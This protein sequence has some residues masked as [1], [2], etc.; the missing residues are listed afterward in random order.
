VRPLATRLAARDLRVLGAPATLLTFAVAAG[1]LAATTI[2]ST[3]AFL[4]DSSRVVHGGALSATV[5]GSVPL[6]D[7]GDLLPAAV[8]DASARKSGIAPVLRFAGTTPNGPVDVLGVDAGSLAALTPVDRALFDGRAIASQLRTPAA[9][10]ALPGDGTRTL[11][12]SLALKAGAA[13]ITELDPYGQPTGI[14]DPVAQGTVDVSAIAWLADPQGDLAPVATDS[15]PMG[16]DA[17]STPTVSAPVPPGGPWRLIA[18]DLLA[19]SD[20]DVAEASI[21][22]TGIR[23][24]STDVRMPSAAWRVATDAYDD[25]ALRT[26]S[27]T[28]AIGVSTAA[29]RSSTDVGVAVR[30]VPAGGGTVPVAISSSL[31]QAQALHVGSV[32]AVDS[33]WAGLRGRVAAIVP[34]VPGTDGGPAVLADLAT[35][36]RGML[37]ASQQ[38]SRI[39]ELWAADAG[40]RDRIAAALPSAT[41]TRPSSET[42]SRFTA[43]TGAELLLGVIAAT[44]FAVLALAAAAV[45][46]SRDRDDEA[47]G[48]RVAGVRPAE[49]GLARAFGP[50]AVTVHAVVAGLVAGGITAL[51]VAGTTARAAAPTAPAALPVVDAIA[52]PVVLCSA[53]V[54]L[55]GGAIV[56]VVH[57][58]RIRRAAVTAGAGTD[59]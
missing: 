15:A 59:G 41:I 23:D 58:L 53:G 35:L 20:V 55:L 17:T 47:R 5:G 11:T 16:S 27:A 18:L 51:L 19:G 4:G 40:A 7:P 42:E 34:V 57:G 43:L 52:W 44:L 24:G 10:L 39:R 26:G 1:V 6:S 45:S 9:G 31:A 33:T 30:L 14:V 46:L 29:L 49:Q 56:A 38:P 54:A 13:S 21:R 48:L 2:G 8:R 22:V 28:G 32:L 36:D 12:L 25:A 50:A 37:A 3:A